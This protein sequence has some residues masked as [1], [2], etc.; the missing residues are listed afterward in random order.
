MPELPSGTVTFLFT[1]IEGSTALWERDRVAMHA[2]VERHVALFRTA[3]EAHNGVLFKVV[4][5]AV[6]A[7][8]PTAPKAVTAAVEGQRSLLAEDWGEIGP[9]HVRMALH[10]GEALPDDRGDYLAAPLN[11]L[12]RL[13]STGYG[14]QILLSQSVQQLTRG[15]LPAGT[16]LRDLG[17]HRLRDLLE[18]ERVFQLVHPDLPAEFP[19]LRTLGIRPNNL[20][21]QPTPL[22][23]R[24]REVGAVAEL[25]CSESVQL[26][27]LTGP[28]GV[29]KTR[30]GLQA[31]A[32]LLEAFPD[33]AFFVELAPLTDPALV[34][35]TV[36][37]VLGVKVEAGEPAVG[38]LEDFLRDRRLLLLLDNVE[39]LLPAASLVSDLLRACPR[40]KV[41]AT[42][43]TP[44]R[45]RGEREFVIAP[46]ALPVPQPRPD[47]TALEQNSA[48]RLFVARAQE[49]KADFA[50]TPDNA[51]AIAETVRRL[52]GLPL[53]LE[54]AAARLRILTPAA[55]LARLDRRLP[56]LTGGSQDLPERQKTLRDTIAW[57]VDLLPDDQQVLLRRLAVFAGGATLEAVEAVCAGAGDGDALDGM[58]GL[59]EQSLVRQQEERDDEPRFTML[60]TIREFAL[61]QLRDSGEERIIREAQA[62]W[63]LSLA[64]Q[65]ESALSGPEEVDWLARLDAE[66]DNLR[67]ALEWAADAGEPELALKLSIALWPVWTRQGQVMEGQ[68]WLERTLAKSGASDAARAEALYRLG[69]SAI[70]LSDYARARSFYE[71]S[72]ELCRAA[73]DKRGMARALTGLGIVAADTGAFAEARAR[74]QEALTIYERSG[75]Q[76]RRAGSLFNLGQVASAEGDLDEAQ[77]THQAAL[78]VRR[79]MAGADTGDTGDIG[80]SLFALGQVARRQGRPA[81]AHELLEQSLQTFRVLGDRQG[82][83]YAMLERGRAFLAQDLPDRALPLLR[84]ATAAF[85]EMADWQCVIDGLEAIA[86]A[87]W[88]ERDHARAARLLSATSL[89]R[90]HMGLPIPPVER[91]ALE[92]L[93]RLAQGSEGHVVGHALPSL[94]SIV[95]EAIAEPSIPAQADLRQEH[96]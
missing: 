72:L 26:V 71:A 91:P 31:A 85:C 8:F 61:E 76:G 59:V 79:A 42:S 54:L 7:A 38:A 39:H 29:G 25:L 82:T 93:R 27:T 60:E 83:A 50:L 66:R 69:N 23:G 17:E 94:E 2:A 9:L 44:L 47:L 96:P 12:A 34:P 28:G 73:G 13:L 56:L 80:F 70:D 43:R 45:L 64:E 20:P 49:V 48:V 65:A 78:D 51:A 55:L 88:V 14:G 15:A 84:E 40:L 3:I 53:A 41:L 10:V 74:Y 22:V 35:S 6:Q 75:D 62:A 24:E 46:L 57:S 18:P 92:E 52:D 11:R 87:S 30:L 4:G 89:W 77:S 63:S 33:G 90:E 81:E 86:L 67:G 68:R 37:R 5:D 36:A 16:K 1:D 58:T 95:R 19:P 21:R 32:D